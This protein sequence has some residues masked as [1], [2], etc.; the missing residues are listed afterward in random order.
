MTTQTEIVNRALIAIAARSEVVSLTYDQSEAARTMRSLYDDTR[1]ALLRAAHWNFA[2]AMVRLTLRKSAPGTPTNPTA[3]QNWDP[4]TMPAIPWLY[5]YAVPSDCLLV[6]TVTPWG[7]Y[8][9]DF[10]QPIFSVSLPTA[11]VPAVGAGYCKF[12]LGTDFSAGPD[13]AAVVVINTN[14]QD[15]IATYT[16]RITQEQVWDPL[17][18]EA[19]VYGL[20]ARAAL[21]LTGNVGV[22]RSCAEQ[23]MNSLRQARASDGNEGITINDHIPDWLQVRGWAGDWVVPQ[24]YMTGWITPSFLT[25]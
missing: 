17:F 16:R 10:T 24:N 21:A 11:S 2:K 23:A 1:D 18:Q 4:A 20:A 19:M 9:G 8:G 13:S 12:E 7:S 15:A 14:Q 22:S 5:Q 6:R 3:A 25:I